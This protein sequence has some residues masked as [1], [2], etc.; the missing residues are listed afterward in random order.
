MTGLSNLINKF[1]LEHGFDRTYYLGFSGGLDSTVLL[2]LLVNVRSI[3]PLRLKAIHIHHGLSVNADD[4]L[5]HC[6]KICEEWAVDFISYHVNA[7]TSSGESPEEIARQRRYD[8]FQ[9]QI[10]IND[11]LL[12]AHHQDDQAETVLLQLFRGAG[13]KGLSGM[14]Q[15][16][17][18]KQ[19]F[20]ARPLLDCSRDELQRYAQERQLLWIDDES[21]TNTQFTRNFLRHDVITLLKTRW[22]NV[23]AA[24]TRSAS[25]CA[26]TQAL[27]DEIAQHDL[28][29]C[30]GSKPNTLSVKKLLQLTEVRQRQT[31]RFWLRSRNFSIP[32]TIKMQ[33]IINDVLYA[34]E[35]KLPHVKWGNCELRR[36]RDD[37]YVMACLSVF[38]STDIFSWD[39]TKPLVLPGVG[40]LQVTG[41]MLTEAVTVRFRHGGEECQLAG[42]SHHHSLKKLFQTWGVPPWQ[43]NR[44][45]L[46]FLND[47][48]IAAVGFFVTAEYSQ[49]EFRLTNE[50]QL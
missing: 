39:L 20:L 25:H 42:R 32:S 12:T 49:M 50:S 4:W 34:A 2:H 33:H 19:G 10:S 46:V 28:I 6:K 26:E 17:P 15:F 14:P 8:I 40:E 24:I 9:Q 45:P 36:Y 23:A 27:L 18:F 21:N 5:A 7:K 47:K 43:R 41:S 37:V 35:D 29:E 13:P 31:I 3:Y 38:S 16:A 48:L 44:I 22:P 11:I 1:C 30:Y